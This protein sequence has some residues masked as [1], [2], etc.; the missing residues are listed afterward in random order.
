LDRT[1]KKRE[2]CEQA[3]T[4]R[5]ALTKIAPLVHENGLL[6]QSASLIGH[7][8]RTELRNYHQLLAILIDFELFNFN[9]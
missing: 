4:F 2:L 5:P 7:L 1:T 9:E 8:D 3:G 6:R